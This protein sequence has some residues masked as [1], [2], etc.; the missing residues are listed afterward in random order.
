[1]TKKT[2][3]THVR[4]RDLGRRLLLVVCLGVLGT[5]LSADASAAGMPKFIQ[6]DDPS[7]AAAGV[8]TLL[9]TIGG[10]EHAYVYPSGLEVAPDGTIVV[11]DIGNDVV[12]KFN[13]DGS[14]VWQVGAHG[15]GTG[16]FLMPRD[17]G[18]D[19]AGNIFV[20]DAGNSR[21]VKLN[22]SGVWQGAFNGAGGG[23]KAISWPL[24]VTVSGNKVYVADTGGK[25]VRVFDTNGVQLLTVNSVGACIIGG[26]RDAD[27]DASGN[28][29][30]ANYTNNN[31][32]KF[33]PTGTQ[34]LLTWG[35]PGSDNGGFRAVYGVRLAFDPVLQAQEV[36]TADSQN[37]RVQEFTT[38]GT[39]I[40]AAGVAGTADQAGTFAYMRRVAV[41]ANGDLWAV[42]L[43]AWRVERWKRNATAPFYTYS[44]QTIGT[45]LPAATSTSVFQEVH[46]VAFEND[47][48][49]DATDTVHHRFARFTSTGTL[50]STC[51]TRGETLQGFNW[52][53]GIAVDP[54]TNQIWAV[55]TK[56]QRLMIMTSNCTT[57]VII[58]PATT[59]TFGAFNWPYQI[60]IRASDRIAWIADTY[61]NRIIS[62][63]V[64]TQKPLAA[65]PLGSFFHPSAIAIDPLN[66]HIL[67]ADTGHN[68]IVEYS[69]N[70]GLSPTRVKG[71]LAS[72]NQPNGVAAD[73]QGRIYIADTGNNKVVV[74]S[75]T[76]TLLTTITGGFNTPEALTL[77]S[78]GNIYVSDTYNDQIQVFSALP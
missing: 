59:S 63:D 64:A 40:A 38:G 42:D 67:V 9:R 15:S 73:S 10:P 43:W 54:V 32:L 53:R 1:M 21:I 78:A 45:I 48:T 76:G 66:G 72:L 13:P 20:A 14:L 7:R 77:D 47:G 41:D 70:H 52:P 12:D 33:N 28:I 25:K 16:Q 30:V 34:C 26:I 71:Y 23:S 56:A 57:V 29:Y 37:E 22:S 36:Y 69:D 68:K 4:T 49:I 5:G 65:T 24:G 50:L 31:I 62:Y 27:A 75:P 2:T 17:I 51:G 18:I 60:A 39:F 8:T 61:N 58:K 11:S 46:Q 55:D 19:S 3:T 44:G 6:P 35:H 74:L